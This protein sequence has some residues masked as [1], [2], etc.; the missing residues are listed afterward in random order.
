MKSKM[1]PEREYRIQTDADFR[2]PQV[3]G[4]PLFPCAYYQGALKDYVAGQIPWHW[5]ED[6]EFFLVT[7]GLAQVLLDVGPVALQAGDGVLFNANALHSIRQA[8][9]APCFFRSLVFHASLIGG[10]PGGAIDQRHVRPVVGCAALRHVLFSPRE[11]WQG[12][13]LED[14][15]E[16]FQAC[17]MEGFGFEFRV[18]DALSRL[19]RRM[20]ENLWDELPLYSREGRDQS[21]RLKAMLDYIHGHFAEHIGLPD[22]AAAA[23]IG[24][25][26][27]CRC[28]E[29]TIGMP[30]VAYTV[31][32]R[33]C[34]AAA[35]LEETELPMTAVCEQTGFNS[36]SYFSKVFRRQMGCSPRE[37]RER[38]HNNYDNC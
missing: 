1:R 10:R 16:A 13:C 4:M 30:P 3:H 20:V 2:E 22:I 8:G 24:E 27:C 38:A 33:I 32:Y 5:H 17:F 11:P 19:W 9:R 29:G 31:N 12:I 15:Q 14:F 34:A 18:R 37:Y 26:D 6:L 25:R 23:N 7:E 28:F 36:P 35:M 21:A